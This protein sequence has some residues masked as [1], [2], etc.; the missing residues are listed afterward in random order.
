MKVLVYAIDVISEKQ[1]GY[2][3]DTIDDLNRCCYEK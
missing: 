1:K 3:A 2:Y